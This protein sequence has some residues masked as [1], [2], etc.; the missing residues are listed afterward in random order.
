MIKKKTESLLN[1]YGFTKAKQKKYPVVSGILKELTPERAKMEKEEISKVHLPALLSRLINDCSEVSKRSRFLWQCMYK[2]APYGTLP[3]VYRKD[4]K[5][6]YQAKIIGMLFVA[7]V[8]DLADK[9]KDEKLLN[10]IIKIPLNS[11]FKIKKKFTLRQQRYLIISQRIWLCLEKELRKYCYFNKYK[12]LF[13]FYFSQVINS[14]RYGFLMN[15]NLNLINNEEC[16]MY[17]P[18]NMQVIVNYIIDLMCMPKVNM[19][20]LRVLHK[21]VLNVQVMARIANCLGTWERELE[22]YDFSSIIFSYCLEK[23][24]ITLEEINKKNIDKIRKKINASNCQEYFLSKWNNHYCEIKKLNKK[25]KIMDI[26]EYIK[27]TEK[28]LEMYC[29]S[30]GYL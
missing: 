5:S 2:Y 11:D 23:N 13:E 6:A 28:I 1:Y 8:D 22:E 12:S 19:Y 10:E 17:L 18:H 26:T 29:L 20:E 15:K 7:L 25:I 24:I 4:K 14:M 9:Y 27:G 30:K 3:C 21:I 16:L